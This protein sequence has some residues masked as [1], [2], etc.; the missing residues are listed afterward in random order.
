MKRDPLAAV[1]RLRRLAMEDA[2]RDFADCLRSEAET[3]QAVAAVE[4]AIERETTLASSLEGGDAVVEAFGA[5]LKR[6]RKDLHA[7]QS[8]HEQSESETAR[9]RAALAVARAAVKAAEHLMA[10]QEA[11]AALE[12]SRREQRELDEIGRKL[13]E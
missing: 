12:A 6:A 5:W 11:A 13:R 10:E 2:T 8:R 7:A 4:A 9:A 1:L 3:R